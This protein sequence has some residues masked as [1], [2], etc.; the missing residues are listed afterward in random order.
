MPISYD[1]KRHLYLTD[2]NYVAFVFLLYSKASVGEQTL[3]LLQYGLYN[4][5]EIPENTLIQWNLWSSSYI[6]PALNRYTEMK[7][8]A[9]KPFAK[10]FTKFLQEHTEKKF[11][12]DWQSLLNNTTLFF[13]CKIPCTVKDYEDKKKTISAI[14]KNIETSFQQANLNPT[15]LPVEHYLY[16]SNLIFNPGHP[17]DEP[18]IYDPENEI[19]DQIIKRDTVIYQN[20]EHNTFSIDGY[21]GKVLS[22]KVYPQNLNFAN[23]GEF[24]GS[25]KHIN[26]DQI[27]THFIYSFLLRKTTEKEEMGLK[28]KAEMIMKQKGFSSL[29]DNIFKRQQDY[30]ASSRELEEGKN[31][32]K[33]NLFWYLY[34]KDM[35]K[36]T[37]ASHILKNIVNGRGVEIQEEI[38]PI[39]FMLGSTP[40]N[41]SKSITG[42][43]LRR[44]DTMFD[45]NA[46]QLSPIE[47][48]WK[49]SGTPTVPLVSRRGQLMFFDLWDTQGGMNA[50]IVGPMGQGKSVFTNHLIFNYRS[51]PNTKV[52]I[53]DVGRSY[54]GIT[55]LFKGNFVEPSFLKPIC[56]NPFSN[57]KD[58]NH[59]MNFLVDIVDQMIKPKERCSDTERGVIELSVRNAL[60]KFGKETTITKV[61]DEMNVIADKENATDFKRLAMYNLLPWCENGQYDKFFSGQSEIELSNNL[62]T[63][64]LGQIKDDKKLTNVLLTTIFY[65]F[66]QEIYQ[67]DRSIKKLIVWD[68]A[69]RF[70]NNPQ[71]LSFIEMGSREYRKFNG[72]LIFI[73]QHLSDLNANSIVRVM[74][75]N[76]E[77]IF[78]FWQQPEEWDRAQADK[79]LS[80]SNYEKD[81]LKNTL[82]TAKGL[83]SEIFIMSAAYGRGIGRLLLP[84]YFYWLYTTD[85]I[86]VAYRDKIIL[87]YNNDF[88]KAIAQCIED[89]KRGLI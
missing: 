17:I 20:T 59:D 57:V 86:E 35:D 83:Y 43:N 54:I 53:I 7:D 18:L 74:K 85:A 48:D 39:P 79:Q 65:H 64:D 33:G 45:Y 89:K 60:K 3:N 67:G 77:Y 6:K 21:Y 4:N 75:A 52:R 30:M 19:R 61:R 11:T 1:D 22:V 56:I 41:L 58:I 24:I 38:V 55:T 76:S 66:N 15:D 73:T 27:G 70:I 63:I 37:A 5:K 2:D 16:F 10:R 62:I 34:D 13:T 12:E 88:D 44:F 78:I 36:L 23:I 40:L 8:D 71:V 72:S 69:W 28:T 9:Y 47:S 14:K 42:N 84:K 50:C 29:S 25:I 80:F 49:G 26:R 68:E 51:Q 31:I 32:W 81:I 82:K 87:Q 46:A